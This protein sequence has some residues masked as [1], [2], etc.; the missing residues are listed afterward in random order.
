MSTT[1]LNF[2]VQPSIEAFLSSKGISFSEPSTH[3][4]TYFKTNSNSTLRIKVSKD[5]VSTDMKIK[6]DD[7]GTYTHLETDIKDA[8]ALKKIYI[9]LG[10]K[11]I[12]TFH[13]T[14]KTFK[15]D[16]IRLDLDNVKELGT[17]L[18][19]KFS[20]DNLDQVKT[21][22]NNINL[23]IEDADRRSNIDIYQERNQKNQDLPK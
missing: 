23:K 10:Y 19:V 11:P 5:D 2:L 21:F 16:I 12:V 7:S 8:E 22:L 17:F 3:E 15:N 4:Y 1:Q 18:E 9:N 6:T 13:K 20:K 14:R